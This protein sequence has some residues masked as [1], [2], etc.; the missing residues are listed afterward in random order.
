[1][2]RE[3]ITYEIKTIDQPQTLVLS[4]PAEVTFINVSQIVGNL[5]TINSDYTLQCFRDYVS[6]VATFPFELK[7]KNNYGEEDKTQYVINGTPNEFILKVI[8]KYYET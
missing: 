7:L 3:K 1:M 8:I 4:S 2:K 5:L 6:G